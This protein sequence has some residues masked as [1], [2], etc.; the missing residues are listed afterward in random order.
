MVI[1][2]AGNALSTIHNQYTTIV[3]G[4]MNPIVFLLLDNSGK[5]LSIAYW[6]FM[7]I[8]LL[9]VTIRRLHDADYFGWYILILLIP[10]FGTFTLMLITGKDSE[11]G[12]NKWGSDPK[13]NERTKHGQ[14]NEIQMDHLQNFANNRRLIVIESTIMQKNNPTINCGYN[15]KL[16][17]GEEV[18]AYSTEVV[19]G[20]TWTKI[21]SHVHKDAGWIL[22]KNLKE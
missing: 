18:I 21:K 9:A 2:L 12:K 4:I 1:N 16:E 22:S 3:I 17:K 5:I 8:P 7:I 6:A 13:L 19:D 20:E 14:I 15:T 10:V 11:I